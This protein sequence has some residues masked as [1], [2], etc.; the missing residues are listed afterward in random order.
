MTYT[1][2]IFVQLNFLNLN[3]LIS[4][5]K[6]GWKYIVHVLE[7]LKIKSHFISTQWEWFLCTLKLRWEN[8]FEDRKK[9]KKKGKEEKKNGQKESCCCIACKNNGKRE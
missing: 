3:D 4:R 8:I 7:S 9:K 6:Y 5:D 2:F 1:Y